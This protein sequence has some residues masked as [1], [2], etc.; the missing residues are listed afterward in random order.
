M[1]IYPYVSFQVLERLRVLHAYNPGPVHAHMS[2]D[3]HN[4]RIQ[5][6]IDLAQFSVKDLTGG[7]IEI[8]HREEGQLL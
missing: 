7:M 4:A 5:V 2:N 1:K 6:E 3:Y 8:K